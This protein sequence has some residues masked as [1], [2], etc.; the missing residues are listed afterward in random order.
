MRALIVEDNLV[1]CTVLRRTLEDLPFDEI[2]TL[3]TGQE[4]R[5]RLAEQRFDVVLVDW[6]LPDLSGL[7]VVKDIRAGQV[8][9]Q[10]LVIMATAKSLSGD[11][12]QAL[13]AGVDDYVVKPIRPAV[14]RE[15]V[16]RLLDG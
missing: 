7:E 8:N 4:A 13:M 2:V 15:K 3:H 1:M 12:V 14:L 11:I 5:Q 6:M 16:A 9:R 10:S